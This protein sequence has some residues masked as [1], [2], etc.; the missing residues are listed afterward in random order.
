MSLLGSYAWGDSL[1]G[2]IERALF[3][4]KDHIHPPVYH[5]GNEHMGLFVL[6][7]CRQ[8]GWTEDGV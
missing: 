8:G 3:A 6:V 4:T 1:Y 2:K 7:M 5:K